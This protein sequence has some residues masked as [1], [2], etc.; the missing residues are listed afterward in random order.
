MIL[1]RDLDDP[2]EAIKAGRLWQRIHL[3]ATVRGVAVQPLNQ[4]VELVD[5]ERQLGRPPRIATRLRTVTDDAIG[6]PTFAFR[7]GYPTVAAPPSP[8][9]PVSE[10]LRPA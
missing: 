1:V 7:M 4:A 9:R 10:V 6:Q 3:E 5:R 2:V 8:R